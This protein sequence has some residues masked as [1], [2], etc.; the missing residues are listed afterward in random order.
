[1][2]RFLLALLLL[3]QALPALAGT[4]G[5]ITTSLDQNLL[6]DFDELSDRKVSAE[7]ENLLNTNPNTWLHAESANFVYHFTD[8]KEA[9]TVVLHAE[10]YFDWI[11]QMFGID[12]IPSTKKSHVFIFTDEKLWDEFRYRGTLER[13]AGAEAFTD[14]NEL[15]IHRAQFWLEPQRVLAHELTHVVLYR[16]LG[17]RVP[18]YLNEGYA[19]F[20]GF[21]AIALKFGGDEYAMRTIGKVPE[22][23][24]QPLEKLSLV[25]VYPKG[26][27]ETDNFY[28]ESQLFVRF[29]I[30][31]YG[32]KRLYDFL[33]DHL[34]SKSLSASLRRIYQV[35][36]AEVEKT[37][38][39]YAMEPVASS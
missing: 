3:F 10:T 14:G 35:E 15:F 37:F 21:K 7:A 27:E 20:I 31:R 1:M 24:Y 6:K 12:K 36:L 8:A 19:D 9:E 17:D 29:L 11:R 32:A 28:L 18:L 34:Q 13:I 39:S 23:Y 30:E 2:K 4:S 22:K 5:N 16:L 25:R 33:K 38:R 26:L